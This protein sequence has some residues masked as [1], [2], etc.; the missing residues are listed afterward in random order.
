MIPTLRNVPKKQLIPRNV[1]NKDKCPKCINNF[2]L[3]N[4]DY[5]TCKN[6]NEIPFDECYLNEEKSTYYFCNNT[7][8]N[9]INNC[10]RCLKKDSCSL[11]QD[12]YTFI[13]DNKTTCIKKKEIEGKYILDNNDSSNYIKCSQLFK[14]CNLCYLNECNACNEGFIFIDENFLECI[15]K[16]T[17]NFDEYFTEDNITYYSC[18]SDKYKDNEKCKEEA[19]NELNSSQYLKNIKFLMIIFIVSLLLF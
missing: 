17:I 5:K 12:E 1:L 10:K 4:E 19:N 7:D 2:F 14:D 16:E 8:Y 3:F 9:S 11:C 18:K 13:N 6:K 15:S